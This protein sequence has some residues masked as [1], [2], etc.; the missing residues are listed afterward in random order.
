MANKLT[1]EIVEGIVE[2]FHKVGGVDY[3]VEVARRDPPTF[4]RL[5]AKI[6][7]SE[8]N[9]QITQIDQIDIGKAMQVAQ[10]RLTLIEG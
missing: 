4:C 1:P 6:I 7:P 8:I 10:D 5:V 2:A 3:L 9:A